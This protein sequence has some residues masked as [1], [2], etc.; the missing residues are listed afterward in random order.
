MITRRNVMAGAGAG[1]LAGALGSE[2]EI[3][4]RSVGYFARRWRGTITGGARFVAAGKD[5]TGNAKWTT[6]Q[7]D[8][9]GAW[10]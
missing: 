2:R 1:A 10:A 6:Q 8:G 4:A 3:T 5:R 7:R 9:S